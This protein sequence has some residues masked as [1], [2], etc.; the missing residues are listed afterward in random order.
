LRERQKRR[1]SEHFPQLLKPHLAGGDGTYK[2]GKSETVRG[3]SDTSHR[4]L[5]SRSYASLPKEKGTLQCAKEARQG[6]GIKGRNQRRGREAGLIL[7]GSAPLRSNWR[8]VSRG[9]GRTGIE[10][11]RPDAGKERKLEGE[12]HNFNR[13]SILSRHVPTAK[14]ILEPTKNMGQNQGKRRWGGKGS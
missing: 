7:Y 6:G 2:S 5:N 3:R 13:Q 10:G 12:F 11:K 8:R 1:R 4:K 14:R 9:P